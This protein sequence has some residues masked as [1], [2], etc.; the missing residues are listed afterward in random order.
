M[1]GKNDQGMLEDLADRFA[2]ALAAS[3]LAA[4]LR[5]LAGAARLLAAG[6]P[7]TRDE[8]LRLERQGNVC[9]DWSRVRRGDTA[10]G[11]SGNEDGL[12]S[13]HRNLFE[14]DVLLQGFRGSFAGPDG[15]EWRAGLADCRVRDAVIGNACLHRIDRLERQIIED[16]AVVIG[17]GELDCPVPTAFSLGRRIHPG[18][19]TAAR[20]VWLWDLLTLDDAAAAASLVPAAQKAFQARLDPLL[21]PLKS[22][23]GFVGRG[24]SIRQARRILSA[25]IGPG[26]QVAGASLIRETALVAAPDA[27]CAAAEDAWIE[28]SLL[29]PGARVESG[30]KVARSILLECGEVGWGGMVSQ[31]VIGPETHIQKGEVTASLLGPFVG[32][33]HQSL[34]ISALWP[35]GR[36][37]IA[38]GANVGSNHTGKKPDQEIRP[39]EGNFFGLGCS[40]K[41]PANYEDAPYSLIATGVATAPQRVAFPFS[42]INEPG[43]DGPEAAGLNEIVPGWMWSDN[44]YALVRRMY[45]FA[46][47]DPDGR[48]G[49]LA[50]PAS[51]W[52]TGFFA[53]R[54]FAPA[55]ARK[56]LKARQALRAA[57]PD[58]P[59]YLEDAVPGLGKNVLRAKAREKALAAYEDYLAFFLMRAYADRPG[60][61]WDRDLS[62]LV[63][64]ARNELAVGLSA[65]PDAR[66]W[67]QAQRFRLPAFRQSMLASLARDDKRG[68]RIFDDYAD[69]HP[70][71]A[72]DAAVARLAA[73]LEELDQR[74]EAFIRG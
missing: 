45:K 30:G 33:H 14:G 73:D 15:R 1:I 46:S 52:K 54:L 65:V 28:E 4:D 60:E 27:P 20:S 31:S 50:D 38:Y 64:A 34:L 62:D 55:L 61:A 58:L 63:A 74:L 67:A 37:N 13:V 41:F 24:A 35:E 48:H 8:I 59:F 18:A 72:E 29:R 71:P 51:A 43:A 47:G 10:I 2:R 6:R 7:L 25:Y 3:G 53:G 5:R 21:A 11:G 36:G 19:E 66:S 16:G 57:P 42:L 32:F 44:A 69:F 70:A 49:S 23:F 12:A 68:R 40:I 17:V 39:G 22:A 26:A 56:V 9:A